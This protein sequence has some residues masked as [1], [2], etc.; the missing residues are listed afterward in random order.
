VLEPL[1]PLVLKERQ[2]LQELEQLLAEQEAQALQ[3]LLDLKVLLVVPEPAQLLA[4]Q[5]AQ[6]LQEHVVL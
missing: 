1:E 6:A 4:E 5:E 3:A 2:V